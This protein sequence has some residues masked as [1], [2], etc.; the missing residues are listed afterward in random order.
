MGSV[1]KQ[2]LRAG[3]KVR[4]NGKFRD[5][6]GNAAPYEGVLVKP[7]TWIEGC[8]RVSMRGFEKPLLVHAN[9]MERA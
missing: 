9:L 6:V 2:T 5:I 4:T 8:W 1:K 3:D 7:V